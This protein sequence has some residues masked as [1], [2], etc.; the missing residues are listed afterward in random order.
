MPLTD[1]DESVPSSS[2]LLQRGALQQRSLSLPLSRVVLNPQ[3]FVADT[4]EV[5]QNCDPTMPLGLGYYAHDR[6][7]TIPRFLSLW[8]MGAPVRTPFALKRVDSSGWARRND[9]TIQ[10]LGD[11]RLRLSLPEEGADAHGVATMQVRID[12][13]LPTLRVLVSDVEGQWSVHVTD[14][15]GVDVQL[16]PGSAMTGLHYFDLTGLLND[17]EG[18]RVLSLGIIR[19]NGD[20]HVTFEE[21][22]LLSSLDAGHLGAREYE[23]AWAPGG[24]QMSAEYGTAAM[25][26]WDTFVDRD[27]LVREFRF[28]EALGSN[29]H[30]YLVGKH[31]GRPSFT[32]DNRTLTFAAEGI[33]AAVCLPLAGNVK[34]YEDE[35]AFAVGVKGSDVPVGAVGIWAAPLLPGGTVYRVG[36]GL[37]P[38]SAERA[39]QLAA[40]AVRAEASQLADHWHS[41][42]DEFLGSVPQPKSFHIRGVPTGG[43]E[44]E[45]VRAAYYRAF[46]GLYANVLPEQPEIGYHYPTI[47]TGKG[48]M[49]NHGSAGARSAAAWETFLAIQFLSFAEPNLAWDCFNGL[50][51]RVDAEGSL[52]GESLPSHKAQTAALLYELTGSRRDLAAQY[53]AL[54][55]LMHWQAAR[56]RW[57]YG[58]YNVANEQDAEFVTSLI[59]DLRFASGIAHVL[60]RPSDADDFDR[61]RASLERDY[62]RNCFIGPD[63]RAVQHW[64][65]GDDSASMRGGPDGADLPVTAGLAVPD[66]AA[67]QVESLLARFAATYNADDQLGG[68]DFVK[69]PN[70]SRTAAG[71]IDH[72]RGAQA[73]G[74]VNA[75]LRD[76][77]Q[78][79]SFS[80][81]YDRGPVRPKPWGVRPS[82]F[83][84]TQVIDSVWLNN[85]FRMDRARV[86]LVLLPDASGG[87]RN[88]RVRDAR[89]SVAVEHGDA[90]APRHE[91]NLRSTDE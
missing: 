67:W 76:V 1:L 24:L 49:W 5:E 72:E 79:G 12:A 41:K 68:F 7:I 75:L 86:E 56:P 61:L 26:G 71:L 32:D 33:Q 29:E 59:I 4:T 22:A 37:D 69:H 74:L 65:A 73:Q 70:I 47:A 34:Y 87:V 57:I 9:V 46:I 62:E 45:S 36:C 81:V 42:W 16:L 14:R 11:G 28:S 54:K 39:A 30:F 21:I 78:S 80:E 84:M 90:S 85:G 52:G 17:E 10:D 55:R 53:D 3:N 63:R 38:N 50:L 89:V 8:S 44:A 25:S 13:S 77:I 83:G 40:S 88:I 64:F 51:S 20:A 91:S 66:L 27:S 31:I 2:S 48:S 6:A 19:E 60:G 23:T 82:I 35:A 58:T 18:D 15:E 43:L